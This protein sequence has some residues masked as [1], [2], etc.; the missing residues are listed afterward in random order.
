MESTECDSLKGE[1]FKGSQD[2]EA[3]RRVCGDTCGTQTSLGCN[4]CLSFDAMGKTREKSESDCAWFVQFGQEPKCMDRKRCHEPNNRE[5]QCITGT[6]DDSEVADQCAAEVGLPNIDNCESNESCDGC[7]SSDACAWYANERVARCI[8][9]PR[10]HDRG[11]EGGTCTPGDTTVNVERT[12]DAIASGERPYHFHIDKP[13]F[14]NPDEKPG[15]WTKPIVID[16]DEKP[17]PE[18]PVIE[19]P[20]VIEEPER[21]SAGFYES[22]PGPNMS[23]PRLVGESYKFAEDYLSG[24][25]GPELEIE[26][27]LDGML[28]TEDYVVTRVRLYVDRTD[29]V[30]QVPRVG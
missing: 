1:C 17:D 26:R 12:C 18:D 9:K 4:E 5:G 14:I 6:R 13:Y 19:L 3:N 29:I 27:I 21:D 16:P 28:V 2:K 7:L 23:W 22:M 8:A 10:C 25:Y 24:T 11:F 30:V 20:I 15:D